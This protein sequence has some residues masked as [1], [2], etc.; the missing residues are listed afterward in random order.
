MSRFILG[1]TGSI[2]MGKTTVSNMFRELGVPVWCADTAVNELYKPLGKGTIE[3]KKI[4][5]S[6]I[7]DSG[8]SKEKLKE[9]IQKDNTK[10][11]DVSTV[12]VDLEDVFLRLTKN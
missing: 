2:A 7:D 9:L 5:P 1:L 11:L 12:D 3:I 6:V 10:I 4:F 8:V